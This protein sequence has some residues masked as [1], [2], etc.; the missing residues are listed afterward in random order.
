[1]IRIVELKENTQQRV[2]RIIAE[3]KCDI[4]IDIISEAEYAKKNGYKDHVE[5]VDLRINN[6]IIVKP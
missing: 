5:G 2:N 3:T 4:S 6:V 1:M